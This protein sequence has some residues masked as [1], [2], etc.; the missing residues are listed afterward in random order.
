MDFYSGGH[1]MYITGGF[2]PQSGGSCILNQ[3]LLKNFSPDSFTVVSYEPANFD[4]NVEGEMKVYRPIKFFKQRIN[5]WTTPLQAILAPRKI[6]KLVQEKNAQLIF[7]AYPDLTFL[8]IAT[9]VSKMTNL[10]LV[11]YLHDT[12]HEAHIGLPLEARAKKIQD[13]A[14]EQ[15]KLIFVMSDGMKDL[16][17]KKYG[18]TTYPLRHTYHPQ[19]IDNSSTQKTSRTIF[20][21]GAIY[22]INQKSVHKLINIVEEMADVHFELATKNNLDKLFDIEIDKLANSS[23]TFYSDS[24]S[25][26]RALS[27]SGCLLLTLDTATDAGIHFDEISTIFPTKAIEYMFSGVPILLICPENYFLSQFF[28]QHNC[29]TVINDIN[30]KKLVAETIEKVFSKSDDIEQ[31]TINAKTIAEQLF[32]AENVRNE[33]NNILSS[34]L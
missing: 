9:R 17:A 12:V 32:L 34:K 19:M 2:P 1:T 16:Y 7:C 3:N 5:R 13:E 29:G 18:L 20:W 8:K 30:N 23:Q 11:L 21:G 27:S 26:K 15:A 6:A 33:F 4:V 28:K 25:Y 24:L 31:K 22:D 10:P 14:F